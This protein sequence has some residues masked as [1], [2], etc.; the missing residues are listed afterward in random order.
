LNVSTRCGRRPKARQIRLDRCLAH[1]GPPGHR[2]GAPVGG[3]GA[4]RRSTA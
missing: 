2:P 4:I 1:P 3:V